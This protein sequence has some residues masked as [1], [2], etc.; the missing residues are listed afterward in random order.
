VRRE[1]PARVARVAPRP[2]D[3][4]CAPRPGTGRLSWWASAA[5]GGEPSA[6]RC[7]PAAAARAA[8]WAAEGGRDT[9]ACL[10]EELTEKRCLAAAE[11]PAD[12]AAFYGAAAGRKD[13]C[14]L[15]AEAF[16][17]RDA[18]H[19]AGRARVEAS[20]ALRSHCTA[21]TLAVSRCL[22]ATGAAGAPPR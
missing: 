20:P 4:A 9:E 15:W 6:A 17:F 14:A 1:A 21:A 7:A 10:V 8:C 12:A 11:C 5:G 18:E 16:A 13:A 3:A 22:S 19:A 2:P